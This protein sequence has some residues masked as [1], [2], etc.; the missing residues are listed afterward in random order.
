MYTETINF[1]RLL[2]KCHIFA[3]TRLNYINYNNFTDILI[4]KKK[5][6][7]TWPETIVNIT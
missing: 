2:N 3:Y 1:L 7:E 5:L 4:Y 6:S